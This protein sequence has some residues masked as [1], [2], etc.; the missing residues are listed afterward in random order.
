[1]S[2]YDDIYTS[3]YGYVSPVTPYYDFDFPNKGGKVQSIFALQFNETNYIADVTKFALRSSPLPQERVTFGKYTS[4][5]AVEWSL[6]ITAI[7]DGGSAGSLHDFLWN[8]SGL[9]TNFI[10]RP[11]RDFDP[12]DRRFYGGLVRIP[13]KPNISVKSGS[14]STFDYT[15]EVIGHPTRSDKP[16]GLLTEK[17]YDEF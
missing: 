16:L 11:Y 17:V 9:S 12:G 7:F 13:T 8:N 15:F 1:M 14:V 3:T 4:G 10:I 5:R 2:I 6:E